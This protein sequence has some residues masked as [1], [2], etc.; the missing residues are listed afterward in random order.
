MSK[1]PLIFERLCKQTP[2]IDDPEAH[3]DLEKALFRLKEANSEINRA[4]NDPETRKLIEATWILQDRLHFEEQV[5]QEQFILQ[6][7][8]NISLWFSPFLR[9]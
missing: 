5:G 8:A 7:I 9:L 2:V 3:S 4:T 6:S 1:Y